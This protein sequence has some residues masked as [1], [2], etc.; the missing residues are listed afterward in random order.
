LVEYQNYR[1][2]IP[3]EIGKCV[4]A[5]TV[6][7]RYLRGNETIIAFAVVTLSGCSAVHEKAL[8]LTTWSRVA[9]KSTEKNRGKKY[10]RTVRNSSIVK[11]QFKGR[12]N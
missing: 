8:K 7:D 10:K 1:T 4:S 11:G 12:L 2:V 6:A 5:I 3:K 9:F